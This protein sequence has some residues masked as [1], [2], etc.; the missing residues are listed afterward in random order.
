MHT[1]SQ[2]F[3]PS[4]SFHSWVL[5]LPSKEGIS[6]HHPKLLANINCVD[7]M[8]LL[9]R[10]SAIFSIEISISNMFANS[11]L[12]LFWKLYTCM[13]FNRRKYKRLIKKCVCLCLPISSQASFK[14]W[15]FFGREIKIYF[16]GSKMDYKH[17]WERKVIMEGIPIWHKKCSISRGLCQRAMKVLVPMNLVML[18]LSLLV[19]VYLLVDYHHLS[20]NSKQSITLHYQVDFSLNDYSVLGLLSACL[21]MAGCRLK[22]W[23]LCEALGNCQNM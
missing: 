9:T 21:F 12:V 7:T 1:V 10:I 15:F 2:L 22:G 4:A 23:L 14:I 16:L 6:A 17:N 8:P 13:F 19:I 20:S 3:Q 11:T 5:D 18:S